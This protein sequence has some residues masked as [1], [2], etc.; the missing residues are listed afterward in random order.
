MKKRVVVIGSGLAGS[1]ICNELADK[2]D[3]TLLEIGQKDV[4]SYPDIH[5]NNKEL[6]EFNTF[7]FSEGGGSNLWHNGLIPINNKDVD[8]T[9]FSQ[10]LEESRPFLNKAASK[11]LF[12]NDSYA[13]EYSNTLLEMNTLAKKIGIFDEGVDCLLYPKKTK[14]LKVDRKVKAHYSVQ[15][16]KFKLQDK[17]ITTV[18]F[19]SNNKP[20]SVDIDAVVISAGA[21][22]SPRLI[23]QILTSLD[24]PIK[25]L[26]KGLIDHPAGF[27]GKVKFKQSD[28]KLI[29]KFALLDKGDYNCCTGIRLKSDCRKYT[30]F[31]FFRPAV[32]MSNS[33][34]IY[35]Y[36][37]RLGGSKGLKR[38]WNALSLKIF[39]PDILVEIFAHIFGF[40]INS[41]T[42]NILVY[43]QQ[44]QGDNNVSYDGS[45]LNIDWNVTNQE[46]E[47]YNQILK[48]L[49]LKLLEISQETNIQQPITNQ[50][51]RSGAHHSGTV[52]LGKHEDCLLNQD[53]K[54]KC[55]DNA[56]V[57]DGS[58][59]QEHSYANTGLTIG[60]LALRLANKLLQD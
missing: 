45:T 42:F 39:H 46:I 36:K 41:R 38:I 22:G 24:K 48:K 6:A 14:K 26:G 40:N 13:L 50:W 34:S 49:D 58:V 29:R 51:L 54:L 52:S 11:L 32:T 59:I 44:R 18:D 12:P 8:S 27:I 1:L 17:R 53:L 16:I 35:Q 7:C 15:D 2:A 37:S 30:C 43:F 19:T 60:Q 56:Y 47:I 20:H 10:L 9:D 57:C 4:I 23:S 55:S 21:F 28:A 5:F 3:I 25:N 33:L 31:A